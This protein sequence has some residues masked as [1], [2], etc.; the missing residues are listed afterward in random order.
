MHRTTDIRHGEGFDGY[1][2]SAL[3]Q[4]HIYDVSNRSALRIFD[5]EGEAT[6]P[7]L[8]EHRRKLFSA[9]ARSR[10][11]MTA[12][13]LVLFGMLAGL[14]SGMLGIGGGSILVPALIALGYKVHVSIGTSLAVI[15]PATL[16]G[17]L[18]YRAHGNLDAGAFALAAAGACLGAA[19]GA[20]L[21]Q[22]IPSTMLARLLGAA[23]MLVGLRMLLA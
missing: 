9:R 6:Q 11:S 3:L 23:L 2:T 7:S 10:I 15:V 20:R 22:A 1:S 5:S 18:L 19:V 14:L 17:A 13:L 8:E 16:V 12:I 4:R 21:A